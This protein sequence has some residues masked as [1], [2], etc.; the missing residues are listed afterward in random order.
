MD[1]KDLFKEVLKWGS[2][3]DTNRKD[4]IK[5]SLGIIAFLNEHSEDEL[6]NSDIEKLVGG[7]DATGDCCCGSWC[8]TEDF[9]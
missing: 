8:G 2:E 4:A 9:K 1:K 7:G 5:Y 6:T 3:S